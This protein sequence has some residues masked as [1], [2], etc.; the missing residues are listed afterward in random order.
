MGLVYERTRIPLDHVIQQATAY[1]YPCVT[2]LLDELAE[3]GGAG[4]R[5]ARWSVAISVFLMLYYVFVA[6]L[7]V[8]FAT[9]FGYIAARANNLG[10]WYWIANVLGLLIA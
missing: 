5:N 10:N 7:V 6:F 1:T 8:Y 2:C 9:V 4:V 3:E